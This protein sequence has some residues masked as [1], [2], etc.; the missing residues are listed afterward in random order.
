[1]Q[2]QKSV[3]VC[4]CVCV[5]VRAFS[6]VQ[7]FVTPWTVAHQSPLPVEFSRQEYWS[8]LPLP[9]PEDLPDSGIECRSLAL[10]VD[11]L[12]SQPP[13]KYLDTVKWKELKTTLKKK[14]KRTSW[15][16]KWKQ[17]EKQRRTL[18]FW[19]LYQEGDSTTFR[20]GSVWAS[21]LWDL[22]EQRILRYCN[23]Y[24]WTT[25]KGYKLEVKFCDFWEDWIGIFF[26]IPPTKYT[27]P[28]G[29][30]I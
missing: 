9:S 11:S 27:K 5:Y 3:C 1:M 13:G 19:H 29:N 14:I 12:P 20:V 8:G 18:Y 2:I 24:F 22:Q 10:Q 21:Y 23:A 26:L 25:K 30:Y 15:W 6:H 4:V 7:L 17:K 16:L 28:L